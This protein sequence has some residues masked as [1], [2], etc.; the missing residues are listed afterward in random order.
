MCVKFAWVSMCVCVGGG[1]GGHKPFWSPIRGGGGGRKKY[2]ARLE[3][4]LVKHLVT[5]R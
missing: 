1:G 4:G 5:G 3:G 2:L